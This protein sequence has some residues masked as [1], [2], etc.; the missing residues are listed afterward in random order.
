MLLSILLA[1]CH[2]SIEDKAAEE[3]RE[4]TRKYCP[5]PVVNNTRTDSMTF[6]RAT[7]TLLYHC[8]FCGPYDDAALI[9]TNRASLSQSIIKQIRENEGLRKLKKE[10]F[11]FKYIVNSDS[12]P[13]QIIYT[14]LV[15]PKDYK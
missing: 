10:G 6:D 12:H 1:G 3:A 15:T 8:S 2:K 11:S 5:T 14:Q 9:A 13:Q 4:Y 7:R